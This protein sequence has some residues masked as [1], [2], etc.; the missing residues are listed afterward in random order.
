MQ[1]PFGVTRSFDRVKL[2]A[3]IV[4]AQEVVGD[5]KCSGRVAF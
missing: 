3:Q 2:R 5:P 1:A 4:R